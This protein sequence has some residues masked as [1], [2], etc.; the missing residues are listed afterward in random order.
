MM[1][2]YLD[3]SLIRYSE[4]KLKEAIALILEGLIFD[5][6]CHQY[7]YRLTIYYYELGEVKEALKH[8][9]LAL[10]LN[11]NDHFL[12]FDIAPNL[13]KAGDI[14]AIIDAHRGNLN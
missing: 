13:R 4:G 9:E 6:V 5:K 11:F 3:W 1:E 12:V 7:H 2:A 8:L 10:S 14:L